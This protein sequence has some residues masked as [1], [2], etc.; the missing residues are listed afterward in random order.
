MW[1]YI[2]LKGAK[3]SSRYNPTDK[4]PLPGTTWLTPPQHPLTLFNLAL[5]SPIRYTSY[6][7]EEHPSSLLSEISSGPTC[8]CDRSTENPAPYHHSPPRSK[9]N[10]NSNVII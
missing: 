1:V 6:R 4:S 3:W 2:H 10:G 5:G 9:I 8:L 7:R